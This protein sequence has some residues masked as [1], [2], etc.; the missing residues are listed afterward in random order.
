MVVTV[1]LQPNDDIA[2]TSELDIDPMRGGVMANAELEAKPNIWVVSIQLI[3]REFN[4]CYVCIVNNNNVLNQMAKQMLK[5]TK[6]MKKTYIFLN[7][8]RDFLCRK[9]WINFTLHTGYA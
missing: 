5:H 4:Q 2:K 9:W 6:K 8:Y 1:G 3:Y 7:W